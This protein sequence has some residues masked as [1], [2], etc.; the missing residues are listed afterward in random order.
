M[1]DLGIS[2]LLAY[3]VSSVFSFSWPNSAYL[4]WVTQ[5]KPSSLEPHCRF[6]LQPLLD[7]QFGAE[8]LCCALFGPVSPNCLHRALK[9]SFSFSFFCTALSW[10]LS[11]SLSC[12]WDTTSDT[13]NLKEGVYF[14][15]SFSTRQKRRDRGHG[16]E[17]AQ[18]AGLP[19]SREK[20]EETGGRFCLPG[21][22][23]SGHLFWPGSSS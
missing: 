6:L 12:C 19:G 16:R 18:V 21:P 11:S 20:M 17:A 1:K 4:F 22:A 7:W 5:R 14:G 10:M 3:L 13:H 2:I 9:L 15:H 23:P 8:P